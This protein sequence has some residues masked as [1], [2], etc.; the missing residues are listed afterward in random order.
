[1]LRRVAGRGTATGP[2][3]VVFASG[4]SSHQILAGQTPF[5]TPRASRLVPIAFYLGGRTGVAA[6]PQLGTGWEG[7]SWGRFHGGWGEEES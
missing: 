3:L 1:M 6:V 7:S 4:A 2:S 5:G